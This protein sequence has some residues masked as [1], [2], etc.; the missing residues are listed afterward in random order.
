MRGLGR[1]LASRLLTKSPM[2]PPGAAGL[3]AAQPGPA[4]G[5]AAAAAGAGGGSPPPPPGGGGGGA[6]APPPAQAPAPSPSTPPRHTNRLA[7]SAS[8]Y[9]LEHCENPVDWW[10]WGPAALAAAKGADK[11]ILLSIGYSSCRWCHVQARE[12][13]EDGEVAAAMN[14]GFVCI[15]VDRETRPDVDAAYMAYLTATTGSGGWPLLAFLSPT[16]GP[17]SHRRR[18]APSV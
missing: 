11:P 3:P 16:S 14:A 15:K 8:P 17:S 5:S 10:E 2:R 7:A 6:P 13:F 1:G 18:P 4:R 9:L 12:C